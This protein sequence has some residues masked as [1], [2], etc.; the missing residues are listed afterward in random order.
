MKTKEK[1]KVYSD[2]FDSSTI[3]VLSKFMD[4]K[5]FDVFE[6]LVS[7]GKEAN[8]FRVKKDNDYLAVKIYMYETSNFQN[9][10]NYIY[11][12]VRF[13]GVQKKK[14]PIVHAWCKKEFSNLQ[15]IKRAGVRVP[16]PIKFRNNVLLMDFIGLKGVASP[17]AKTNPPKNP[18]K[19]FKE[20]KN[21]IKNMYQKENLIHGD[22]SEYNVL[23]HREKPVI[24]DV[25][26]AVLKEHPLADKMLKRD[27]DN[28]CKWFKNLGV[29]T[30]STEEIYEEVKNE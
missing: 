19:W 2:V 26:Q 1:F 24:I 9:M 27:I 30:P 3:A 16:T 18:D 21:S 15:K 6:G 22:L 29:D 14:L 10:W 8:V 11:G 28:I 7:S 20:L 4:G 17:I 12:D 13:L 5:Y 23:N 25:S